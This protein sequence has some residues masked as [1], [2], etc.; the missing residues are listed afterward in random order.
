MID[1]TKVKK[2]HF[3]GI[4][5]VG[6]TALALCAQDLGMQV[7]GSDVKEKF[8]TDQILAKRKIDWHLGFDPNKIDENTNLLVFTAAH[9]G[10]KNKEVAWAE[11]RRI[12]VLSQ[13]Q[14]LGLFMK[15]KIGISTCGV[16]GKTTTASMLATILAEAGEK[17]SFAVG[18]GNILPLGVPGRYEIE[19]KYFIAEAD[20]YFEPVKKMPKFLYQKPQIIILTNIEYDHPDV[21]PNLEKTLKAFR[22]FVEKLPKNGFLIANFDNKNVIKLLK[23][24]QLGNKTVETF[25]FSRGA[26]W[27]ITNYRIENNQ[28]HFCLGGEEYSLLLPGRFNAANAAACIIAAKKLS[29]S[30]TKIKRGLARFKGTKRRFEKI[31]EING[32]SLYDDYA[33]HPLQIR[34]TL[35]AAREWFGGRRILAIFQ[36]HTYSRT[37]YLFNDFCKSFTFVDQV[38]ITKIYASA[39]EKED[40]GV[41]GS[42]LAKGIAACQGKAIYLPDQNSIVAYLKKVCRSGDVIF[43]LGAGDIFLWHDK[44]INA[45]KGENLK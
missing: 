15:K 37:K 40:L 34:S 39:R 12:P 20:E 35:A 10:P 44:I 7:T 1:L 29:L 45:L 21:Y 13:A 4:K 9:G 11:S 17:P 2:I 43:T 31:S 18:V 38:I 42:D 24:I 14:A 3:T 30:S 22:D 36:P 6:M 27:Q 33:H 28:T 5:G 25:G 19:G 26:K 32:I 16:G 8:V 41:S 23:L